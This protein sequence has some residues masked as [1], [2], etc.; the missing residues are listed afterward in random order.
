MAISKLSYGTDRVL[1]YYNQQLWPMANIVSGIL[2]GNV[3]VHFYLH[4]KHV[5]SHEQ[6]CNLMW[7]RKINLFLTIFDLNTQRQTN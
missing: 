4:L 2:D 5:A 7:K 6:K 3:Y 1:V